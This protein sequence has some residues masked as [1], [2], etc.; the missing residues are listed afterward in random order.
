MRKQHATVALVITAGSAT[1]RWHLH[2]ACQRPTA[3]GAWRR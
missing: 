1:E 3:T 2:Q